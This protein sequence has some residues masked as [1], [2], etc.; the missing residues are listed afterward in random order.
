MKNGDS[1]CPHVYDSIT[2]LGFVSPTNIFY[3]YKGDAVLSTE[4]LRYHT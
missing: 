1:I 4:V 3:L 2:K